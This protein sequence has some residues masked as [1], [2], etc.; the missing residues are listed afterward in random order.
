MIFEQWPNNCNLIILRNATL[1]K[2]QFKTMFTA[3]LQIVYSKEY[4]VYE[5]N[6]E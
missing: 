6:N 5:I 4:I 3:K 2:N 1:Q